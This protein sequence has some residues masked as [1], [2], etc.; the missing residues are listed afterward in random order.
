MGTSSWLSTLPINEHGIAFRSVHST[1]IC[2]WH[3]ANVPP[4]CISGG[5]FSYGGGGNN[6]DTCMF[7]QWN[8]SIRSPPLYGSLR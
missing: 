3:F 6:Q 5:Q 4:H 7:V 8:L 2:G 1:S